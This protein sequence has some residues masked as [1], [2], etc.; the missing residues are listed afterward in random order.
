MIR[1]YERTQEWLQERARPF[2]VTIAIVVGALV[3]YLAGSYFLD[4]RRS[5]AEGAYAAAAQKFNTPVQ[6]SSVTTPPAPGAPVPYADEQTK[7]QDVATAFEQ[8]AN[9]YSGYYG[10]IGR[11]YAGVAYLHIDRPKGI[12]LLEKVAGKNEKPT[13]DLA[14]LA[15]AENYYSNVEYDKAISI[16]EELLKSAD[17]LKPA[18][19]LSLGRAYERNGDTEK[20]AEAFFEAAKPDRTTPVGADAEKELKRLAPDRLK[21]LPMPANPT[22]QP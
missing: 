6:D 14:R 20:A 18:I 12:G 15:L 9:D 1:M 21:D 3:L 4:Y 13:S 8:L 19:Q 16:Y 22:I 10:N 5:K 17:N 11:Y 7:W 2:V